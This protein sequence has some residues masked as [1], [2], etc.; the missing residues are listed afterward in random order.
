MKKISEIPILFPNIATTIYC[1]DDD[2]ENPLEWLKDSN[3]TLLVNDISNIN[4]IT[5]ISIEIN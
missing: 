5:S 1:R 2:V 3:Q 4:R